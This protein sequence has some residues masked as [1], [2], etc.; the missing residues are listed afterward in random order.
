MSGTTA[1]RYKGKSLSVQEIGKAEGVRFVLGGSVQRGDGKL[2]VNA[3]LSDAAT[4]AQLWS[5]SFESEKNDLFGLQE[6]ITGRIANGTDRAMHLEAVR[7]SQHHKS[8]ER[9]VDLLLRAAALELRPETID[10]LKQTEE[11]YR[12]VLALEPDNLGATL[13][14]ANVLQYEASDFYSPHDMKAVDRAA[15]EGRT[16]LAK[17]IK[18]DPDDPGV[19]YAISV[20]GADPG[21]CRIAVER[22]I[23]QRPMDPRGYTMQSFWYYYDGNP[24]AA[25]RAI[26]TGIALH[27][28]HPYNFELVNLGRALLMLG[29]DDQAIDALQKAL[30]LN[31][32]WYY[33]YAYLALAFADKADS[34]N[35]AKAMLEYRRTAQEELVTFEESGPD[36]SPG[37]VDM[38][39]RRIG[40]N[41]AKLA[42]IGKTG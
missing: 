22:Y 9:T 35:A 37:Y 41:L 4:G 26:R 10:G 36:S 28:E 7:A 33:P 19:Q 16:L 17:A 21:Q 34:M 1:F 24:E 15:E 6:Q 5:Q 30:E 42:N 39:K 23:A 2:K 8:G 3:E 38:W 29:E 40:P 32:D 11:A 14:L 12:R 18:L 13:G 20:G 31:A 25:L 27:P